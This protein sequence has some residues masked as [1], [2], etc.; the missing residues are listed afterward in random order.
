MEEV[1]P[2]RVERSTSARQPSDIPALNVILGGWWRPL[3]GKGLGGLCLSDRSSDAGRTIREDEIAVR[4]DHPLDREIAERVE[5]REQTFADSGSGL[6]LPQA[7]TRGPRL[8]REHCDCRETEPSVI[9]WCEF[10]RWIVQC[11]A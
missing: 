5:R 7:C 3:S 4:N 8:E 11:K 9:V 10:V 2:R 6:A 1:S